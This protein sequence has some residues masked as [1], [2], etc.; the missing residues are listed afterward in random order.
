M[1][2]TLFPKKIGLKQ[3]SHGDHKEID[4]SRLAGL[5]ISCN[6]LKYRTR[7]KRKRTQRRVQP[8]VQFLCL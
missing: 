4:E 8:M 5:P 2:A 6:I 7:K 1:T 3:K